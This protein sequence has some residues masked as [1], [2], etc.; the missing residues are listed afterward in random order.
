MEDGMKYTRP[1]YE[2]EAIETNDIVTASVTANP[3]K[4]STINKVIKLDNNEE[5]EV[6]ATEVRFDVSSL[7]GN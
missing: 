4:V 7:F 3:V 2:I 6:E 1:I 5:I